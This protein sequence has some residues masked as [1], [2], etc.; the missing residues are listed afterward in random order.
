MSGSIESYD[1]DFVEYLNKHKEIEEK[2]HNFSSIAE[3]LKKLLPDTMCKVSDPSAPAVQSSR[4]TYDD[5]LVAISHELDVYQRNLRYFEDKLAGYKRHF[6]RSLVK[7]KQI[8]A[9][10]IM[11]YF[12]C[13]EGLNMKTVRTLTHKSQTTVQEVVKRYI[14]ENRNYEIPGLNRADYIK[15]SPR[16]D[17]V[18]TYNPKKD[19]S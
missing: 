14:D 8:D 7:Y 18:W 19:E 6:L 17:Y 13:G 15:P 5:H 12:E 1:F 16:E 11:E 3:D 2:I 9:V 4:A 10:Q